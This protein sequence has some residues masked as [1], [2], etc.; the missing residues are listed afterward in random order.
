MVVQK[1]KTKSWEEI[2]EADIGYVTHTKAARKATAMINA[3]Y[4]EARAMEK[5]GAPAVWLYYGPPHEI[6]YSF[7]VLD[8]Y[9]ENYGAVCAMREKTSPFLEYAEELGLSTNTC[10]YLRVELGLARCLATGESTEHAPYGGLARPTMFMT[11]GR[12]CDPRLKIFDVTR[13]FLNV[14]VFMFDYMGPPCEDARITDPK[15]CEHY[16]DHFVEGLKGMIAFLEEQTGKKLDWDFFKQVVRNSVEMWHLYYEITELR[17]HIPS[18]MPSGDLYIVQRPFM[19][20][21]GEARAVE[22]L[23]EVKQEIEERIAA[24]VS[25]VPEEKYRVLWLGLPTWLDMGIFNYLESKGAVSVMETIFH[26]Y[27]PVEVD[28][29]DPLR[30]LATKWFWGWDQGGSDGAQVRCGAITSGAHIRD[31]IKE[32]NA[33]GVIAHSVMSCRAVSIGQKHTCNTLREVDGVPVL[34]LESDMTDPRSYSKS[35]A[36]EN[37]DAFIHVLEERK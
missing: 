12:M 22:Y 18:P 26:P 30:A 23:K 24:G 20:M 36:R 13:R 37:V 14:P 1:T 17:K 4:E 3:K 9:P 31:L 33:D 34:I 5:S 16:V 7:G 21:T 29:D 35:E 11:T 10:S 25:V 27:K 19:D 8:A 15:A 28:L 6:F 2:T 32:C